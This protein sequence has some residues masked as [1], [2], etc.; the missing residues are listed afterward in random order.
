MV[1]P[2]PPTPRDRWRRSPYPLPPYPLSDLRRSP[3]ISDDLLRCPKCQRKEGTTH[4]PT[5]AGG[6][7]CHACMAPARWSPS[8]RRPLVGLPGSR[9]R[10]CLL[11]RAPPQSRRCGDRGDRGRS[12]EI[13]GDRGRSS[14][15]GYPL[16]PYPSEAWPGRP[17]P[18]P[19]YP[20][21]R[22]STLPYPPRDPNPGEWRRWACSTVR[23][24]AL[25]WLKD[26]YIRRS[27]LCMR[28]GSYIVCC[29][30]V[31]CHAWP[32]V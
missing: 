15:R 18:L 5:R 26:R 6:E 2:Y 4:G 12:R 11:A 20:K 17:Y 13:A 31:T 16:P 23:R 10:A 28:A 24:S 22:D 29:R 19:P 30:D 9:V 8:A 14:Q 21:Q 25:G 27:V 32:S 1:T 3:T 7:A